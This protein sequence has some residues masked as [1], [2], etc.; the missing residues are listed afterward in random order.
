MSKRKN[1]FSALMEKIWPKKFTR[2]HERHVCNLDCELITGVRDVRVT[3][4]LIDISLGGALFRP[5]K[6]YL[7]DRSGEHSQL[8]VGAVRIDAKIVRTIPMGYSL[9]FGDDLDES[10]L[11]GVLEVRDAERARVAAETAAEPVAA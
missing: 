7:M 4:R 5:N 6:L 9:Q 8:V 1:P 2:R 3:G 11:T 10:L